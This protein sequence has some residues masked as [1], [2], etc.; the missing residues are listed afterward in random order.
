MRGRDHVGT[1]LV[2][3][4]VDREGGLVERAVTL[5]HLAP[6]VDAQQIGGAHVTEVLP[7]TV[8]PEA[9]EMLGIAHGDVSGRALVE[10]EAPEEPVR[11]GEPLL[12]VPALL[13]DGRE[14]GQVVVVV[15]IGHVVAP[16]RRLLYKA[17]DIREA[18]WGQPPRPPDPSS[19]TRRRSLRPARSRP[20]SRPAGTRPTPCVTSPTPP[21]RT[22]VRRAC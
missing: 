9:I 19:P 14:G 20:R 6:L 7:E 2:D 10:T 15:L 13:L 5:D 22:S 8:H 3:L 4:R 17:L 12:A 21:S 11:G 1:R 18:Q 16:F